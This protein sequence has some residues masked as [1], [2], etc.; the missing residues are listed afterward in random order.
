MSL[1]QISAPSVK[2]SGKCGT[3]YVAEPLDACTT[4]SNKVEPVKNNTHDLF[5]LIIRGGCSFEDKVRQAQAAGFK[6][7]IIYNDGY[8][9]LVASNEFPLE[10]IDLV[11]SEVTTYWQY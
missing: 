5:L 1:F 2:G 3:L 7:A 4:L 6:A 11:H 10:I 8:G 9:D